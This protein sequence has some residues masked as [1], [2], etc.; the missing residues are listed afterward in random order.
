MYNSH[1]I[2]IGLYMLHTISEVVRVLS[3]S[4]LVKY[5]M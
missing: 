1:Y 2:T 4:V 5:I 3:C